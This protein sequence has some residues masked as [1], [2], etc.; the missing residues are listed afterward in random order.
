MEVKPVSDE[1]TRF[2]SDTSGVVYGVSDDAYTFRDGDVRTMKTRWSAVVQKDGDAWKLV[3]VHFSSNLLDNPMLDAAKSYAQRMAWIAGAVGLVVG[4]L[5]MA[6]LRA[7]GADE[8]TPPRMLDLVLEGGLVF[9]GTGAPP[10][11]A[12]VGI[13]QGRIACIARAHRGARAGAARLAPDCGSRPASST[14]T[15][16]TTSKWRSRPGSPSRCATA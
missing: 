1:L 13:A 7:G 8:G 11:R 6:L 15:P 5:L 12:D 16:T 4:A 10:R 14:S 9:D 2:V 3:N